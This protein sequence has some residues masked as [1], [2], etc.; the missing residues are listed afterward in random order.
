MAKTITI[1]ARELNGQVNVKS[2]IRHPMETGLRKIKK[3]GKKIPPHYIKEVIVSRNNR[4][5][6]E[7]FWGKSI[8]RNPYLSF[9]ISGSK[10]D[11]IAIS[12]LDNRGNS[13]SA[14]ISVK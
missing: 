1:R 13:D 2:I 8:S 14:S 3:T 11:S 12:W 4:M 6:M 5:V 9:Q 10:G 7:I